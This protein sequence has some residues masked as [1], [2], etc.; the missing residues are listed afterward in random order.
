MPGGLP[1]P[2]SLLDGKKPRK[3]RFHP[4]IEQIAESDRLQIKDLR[5][6]FP[7]AGE[8]GIKSGEQGS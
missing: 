5:E 7:Y 6:Q 8:Q 4:K 1:G 2:A 3:P